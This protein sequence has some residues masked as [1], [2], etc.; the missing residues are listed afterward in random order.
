MKTI[1]IT[2]T[3]LVQGVF[4]RKRTKEKAIELGLTG[5]VQNQ[6][7]GSVYI[8]AT[9]EKAVLD[10]L[11]SWCHTGPERA[12]VK[13]VSTEPLELTSFDSFRIRH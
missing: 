5:F 9:G 12:K 4:Y 11:V 3:G 13:E 2:V 10:E 8:Q 1:A 7:D 6:E